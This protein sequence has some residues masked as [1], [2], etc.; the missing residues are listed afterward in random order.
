[1]LT[2]LLIPL[3]L[4][5]I[6]GFFKANSQ[7]T[8]LYKN[9]KA[10]TEARIQDLLSKMTLMDKCHQLDIWHPKAQKTSD[11]LVFKQCLKRMGDTI[12]DG[13]GFLQFDT[14]LDPDQ[15]AAN[16]NAIQ[17]FFMEQ[18]RLGIPA[19]SNAD[20]CHGF[21]GNGG[22]VFPVP[23]SMGSTWDPELIEEIYIA[24]GQEM[25]WYGITHAATPVLDLLRDPRY[26]RCDE[27][28]SEDPY[29]VG[30]M[31]V[32][33]TWGIQGRGKT[34]ASDRLLACAKHFGAHSEPE[35][36][37]NLAPVNVS[38]RVLRDVHFQAFERVV[39]EANIRT[40]M[41]SYNEI[42]GV[43]THGNPW[44]LNDILRGEWGFTG[45]VIS[46]YD[47][48]RRMI[49]RQ[50]VCYNKADA[51]KRAITS[52]MDFECPGGREN[53]CFVNLPD[54]IKAGMVKE[55]VLDSAVVRVLRNKFQLGLF[56]Q[57]YVKTISKTDR[58][59][60]QQKHNALALKAAEK[61]MI[62][63]KNNDKTLPFDE[64]GIKKLAVIGPNA[65]E[66]HYGTYSNPLQPGVSIVEGL[67]TFGKGKFEVFYSEGFQIYENDTLLPASEKTPERN[68]QRM[69]AAIE[70][71]K[72]CDAVLLVL[73]GNEFTSRE[74]WAE[75]HTGDRVTLDLLGPQDELAKEIFALSKK[76]AV[77]LING[78][79]LA[80]N[81]LAE[82]APAII[83]GY[84]LGEEQGTAVAN[85]LFGKV[86]PG[87]KLTATFPRSAGQLPV[88]YNHKPI[89]HERS[90]V[91]GSYSPLFP[92]G[93]GLSYTTFEY[94]NLKISSKK[95]IAGEATQVSIDVT[96]TGNRE[97]DEVV[98]L[99]IR[100]KISS[101]TRPIKELKD[102]KRIS[103][104]KGAKTTVTFT[105]TADKLWF[106]NLEMQRVVEPGEFEIMVG[107]NSV[108]NL[109]GIFEVVSN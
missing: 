83:E 49:Y 70:L 95:I 13:V 46:D 98:Q 94:S 55:S 86:N 58:T 100:D 89:V 73:G 60:Y 25:R 6:F 12:N 24:I 105:I 42:D 48:V 4:I 80:I 39:K 108:D 66:V 71:A 106:H 90:Y 30:E 75:D 65:D 35:G 51:A 43:P 45:Y 15:Y 77:L 53:Y 23:L 10:P 31:G 16:F 7:N 28:Y 88:Y 63:L 78:R 76:T 101:V 52:G 26:G 103:L 20:G 57:P 29:L 62:L 44:L 34:I 59:K 109:S 79:P 9:E 72:Q 22:T 69:K 54:L 5:L 2:K 96:N 8:P 19:I 92:F 81:Y 93:F 74:G 50:F 21:M 38:E 102:F 14:D 11:P 32:H 67:K 99:Y 47:A 40:V 37:T 97:G 36:G 107:G 17:K 84:Y 1:M 3:A 27:M 56:E 64:S 68:A 87:G 104:K 91:E 85:V 82:N 18:T 61:G 33:A 41:A